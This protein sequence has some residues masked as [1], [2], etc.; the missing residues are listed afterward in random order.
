MYLTHHNTMKPSIIKNTMK[1]SI[2]K[3]AGP[4]GCGKSL[5][6]EVFKQ[7]L[8]AYGYSVSLVEEHHISYQTL[9]AGYDFI[10]WATTKRG[11]PSITFV[12][13]NPAGNTL[14][15]ITHILSAMLSHA[16]NGEGEP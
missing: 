8:G 9:K 13:T 11:N 5:F 2:I 12:D 6:A 16:Q 3:I 4:A 14:K 7:A 15:R 1:P 10:L